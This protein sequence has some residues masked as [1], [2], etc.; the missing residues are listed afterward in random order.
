MNTAFLALVISGVSK[1]AGEMIRYRPLPGERRDTSSPS[2]EVIRFEAESP[3]TPPGETNE[4]INPSF[5]KP[6]TAETVTQLETRLTDQLLQLQ[7]DL[8]EGARINGIPC[9]CLLKHTRVMDVTA[10]ELQS[11]SSKPAYHQIRSWSQSHMWG[12]ETVAQHPPEFFVNMVPELRELRKG[13]TG[14]TGPETPESP[15]QNQVR[16]LAARVK[17]GEMT[18]EDAVSQIKTMLASRPST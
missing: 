18:K 7:E 14:T 12:P 4:P 17:S 1:M 9:D 11:M 5:R 10:K 6:T 15:M 13:L 3:V 2:M 16:A 8:L